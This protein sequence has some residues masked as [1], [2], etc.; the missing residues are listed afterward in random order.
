MKNPLL[1]A[2]SIVIIL[3]IIINNLVFFPANILCWDVFGYY[4][5]LPLKFIYHDLGLQDVSIVHSI[6]E[7]YHN[8]STFYQAFLGP[9]GN[10]V[11]RYTMGMS[12][13]YTPF[14]F[15]GHLIATLSHFPA[16]GFSFPYQYSIFFGGIIYSIL[17][18]LVLSRVLM[19]FFNERITAILLIIVVFGTN[20]S[21]HITMYGQ[22]ANSHNCLF[23]AY[24]LILW[25]T[26]LWHE[27]HKL[28]HIVLLA[29]ACGV[30]I[31]IR[32]SEVVCLAI[33][34]F[35]GIK[36]KKTF[37]KKIQLF[38]SYYLH[39]LVFA[40]ILLLIGSFQFIYWKIQTGKF[41]FNSYGGNAGEGFEFLNPHIYKVLFSFRKGWLIYTPVMVFAIVGF[42]P[43][44]RRNRAVFLSVAVY[45]IFNLYIV[46]SWSA[47]WYAQSFSQRALIPSYPVIAIPFGYFLVWL[48]EQKKVL[49]TTGVVV[50]SGLV[51]LNIF[52]TIQYA[53]GTI[54]GDRMTR[55]YYFAVFGKLRATDKD[56]QLLLVERSF[57]SAESL[58]NEEDYNPRLLKKLDFEERGTVD[59]IPAH[60]G[61]H[62]FLL[63]SS[64][65][66]TPAVESTYEQ[67]TGRDHAWIK[68]TA[69]V[70]PTEN[71]SNNPF[72]LIVRFSHN[73]YPYKDRELGSE[74][75]NLQ[76]NRW[77]RVTYYYLTPEVRRKSDSLKVYFE[78][79]GTGKVYIDD[80]KVE[81]LEESNDD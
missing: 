37:I 54:H 43:M 62:S 58:E 38:K 50:L 34:L 78:N 8:S 42:I 30:T 55:A 52:Q 63:D 23:L 68:V 67:L 22:N 27:S 28:K 75:M 69:Y 39:V 65:I 66:Y 5:Y 19:H 21:L 44:F 16:D 9:E 20:Y 4:L 48:F 56:R 29:A 17:A 60:T 51:L 1:K 14:F 6:L 7:K 26:I 35:W 25:L 72:S 74:S 3:F 64:T 32:P 73:G 59:S 2:V 53:N 24:S 31:L 13:L 40:G 33:P 70:Y 10:Y 45:F 57:D 46:S 61:T 80:L 49:K 36:D 18:I 79:R 76:I 71:Y 47:W 77:N 81:V 11:M 15:I 41:L 12:I